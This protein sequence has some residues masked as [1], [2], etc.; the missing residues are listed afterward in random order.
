MVDPDTNIGECHQ[1][2]ESPAYN[3]TYANEHGLEWTYYQKHVSGSVTF[4]CKDNY[5]EPKSNSEQFEVECVNGEF[6][7]PL[8]FC[9][10]KSGKVLYMFHNAFVC[11]FYIQ[12][13]RTLFMGLN[14]ESLPMV[15]T[16]V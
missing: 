9:V 1:S 2:C 7:T 3:M 14:M 8:K 12:P 4:Q 5:F 11:T 10:E 15:K 6:A 13:V 16:D